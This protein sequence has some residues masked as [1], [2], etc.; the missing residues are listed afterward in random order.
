MIVVH[1]ESVIVVKLGVDN[2]GSDDALAV[3]KSK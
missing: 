2:G 3:L 1:T